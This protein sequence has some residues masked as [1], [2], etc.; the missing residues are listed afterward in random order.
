VLDIGASNI[1]IVRRMNAAFNRG[2][3]RWVG[4]Y[5]PDVEFRTPP[6][7]PEESVYIGH[8]GIRHAAGLWAASFNEYEWTIDRLVDA[9]DCVVALHHH[10]GRIGDSGAWVERPLGAV[11]FLRDGKIVR[12]LSFFSWVEALEAAGVAEE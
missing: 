8:D 1:E 2:D 6:E 11:Y 7:W 4:F 12:V 5:D 10:R 9:A 3:E